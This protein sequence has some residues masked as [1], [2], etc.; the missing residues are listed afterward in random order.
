MINVVAVMSNSVAGI[1]AFWAQCPACAWRCHRQPHDHQ[2]T[3]IRCAERHQT[4]AHD[5]EKERRS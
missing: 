5:E 3:A 2:R 4:R 1:E